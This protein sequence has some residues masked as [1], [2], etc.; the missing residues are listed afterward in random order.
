VTPFRS[1]RLNLRHFGRCY[2][3]FWGLCRFFDLGQATSAPLGRQVRMAQVVAEEIISPS[4][5]PKRVGKER[6]ERVPTARNALLSR[7]GT[8]R[9]KRDTPAVAV[10]PVNRRVTVQLSYKKMREG[11]ATAAAQA[12]CRYIARDGHGLFDA[13]NTGVP[14]SEFSTPLTG[15]P[16]Q[17][18]V[19]LSPEDGAELDMESY[20]RSVM[21]RVEAHVGQPLRWA[22]AVHTDTGQPHAH[23]VIRGLDRDGNPVRFDREWVQRGFRGLATEIATQCLG[24][25]TRADLARQ[26]S[27]EMRQHRW[28]DL[29]REL[30]RQLAREGRRAPAARATFTQA[31]LTGRLLT[32]R[33]LGLVSQQRGRWVFADNWRQLLQQLGRRNDIVARMHEAIGGN[34]ERYALGDD[35]AG[36]GV[37]RWK[38]EAASNFCALVEQPNGRVAYVELR[39]PQAAL[40][41]LGQVVNITQSEQAYPSVHL[42]SELKPHEQVT[43]R[44]RTWLDTLDV[45]MLGRSAAA[46]RFAGHVAARRAFLAREGLDLRTVAREERQKLAQELATAHKRVAAPVT[47][48]GQRAGTLTAQHVSPAGNVYALFLDADG[49]HASVLPWRKEMRGWLGQ[50]VRVGVVDKRV[51]ME[52]LK[53]DPQRARPGTRQNRTQRGDVER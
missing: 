5:Q 30:E 1:N 39:D 24:P 45:D 26:H 29:D 20:T 9:G 14:A 27:Q 44:G 4:F 49:R 35:R 22:A 43:Y 21:E 16:H 19:M 51:R 41:Q 42:R 46:E 33:Q 37:V 50:A 28:T 23:I 8:K 47:H 13:A 52:P 36:T 12:H 38:G 15:E 25:R 10:A 2:G 3:L 7:T 18:R 53:E 11:A 32:L 34:T 17:F 31:H 40:V 48:E 6:G